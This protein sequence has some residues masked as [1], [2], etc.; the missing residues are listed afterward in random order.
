M[1]DYIASI[2]KDY[3]FSLKDHYFIIAT[4][5]IHFGNF[6]HINLMN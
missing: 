6:S 2:V 5:K 3:I 4:F 1:N